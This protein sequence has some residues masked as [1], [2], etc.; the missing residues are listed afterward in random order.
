MKRRGDGHL[1]AETP[2]IATHGVEE[3]GLA[4]WE[5]SRKCAKEGAAG[6]EKANGPL[7][8]LAA[9]EGEGEGEGPRPHRSAREARREPKGGGREGVGAAEE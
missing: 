4:I 5:G 7:S 1:A 2:T 8:S 6:E 9:R 3:E